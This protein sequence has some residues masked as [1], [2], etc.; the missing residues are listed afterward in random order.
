MSDRQQYDPLQILMSLARLL[1]SDD[2]P[3]GAVTETKPAETKD[4]QDSDAP[5]GAPEWFQG[6]GARKIIDEVL[7]RYLDGDPLR[8]TYDDF[9][10]AGIRRGSIRRAIDE[11]EAHGL[12][13]IQKLGRGQ[14]YRLSWLVDSTDNERTGS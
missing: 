1:N 14:V 8:V 11:L 12:L 13:S 7:R 9:E 6:N 2:A 4:G 5:S 10:G 3:N